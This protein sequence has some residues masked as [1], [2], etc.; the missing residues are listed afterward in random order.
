LDVGLGSGRR[1]IGKVRKRG[2][3]LEP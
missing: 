1:A 3:G 2:R